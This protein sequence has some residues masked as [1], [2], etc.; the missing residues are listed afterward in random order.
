MKRG[1]LAMGSALALALALFAPG[2]GA[3]TIVVNDETDSGSFDHSGCGLRDAVEAANDN[4]AFGLCNGD[5]AGPD[6]IVLQSGHTYQLQHGVDDNNVNGDLDISGPTTITTDGPGLATIDAQSNT[7]PCCPAGADRAIHVLSTA[8]AVTLDHLRI[9]E[10]HVTAADF[11]GGGGIL[12]QAP[13]TL[14][15]SVVDFNVVTGTAHSLGGGIFASGSLATLNVV[16]STIADNNGLAVGN[17][18][19]QTTGGGIAAYNASPTVNITNSTVSGNTV[20]GSAGA[21]GGPGIVAGA[22]LGDSG[23]HPF[24]TLNHVTITDNHALQPGNGFNGGL[25]LRAGSMTGNLIAGNTDPFNST[26]DCDIGGVTSGG[27]NL[28]GDDGSVTC[29]LGLLNGPGDLVGS[30]ASPIPAN[31]GTLLDNG[32]PTRTHA[33]NPGSPAIAR[34]GNTCPDTD[35]RGFVRA[36]VAPCDAGAFEAG[37]L[38]PP[39]SSGSPP[40]AGPSAPV[41]PTAPKKKC[42]KHKKHKAAAAKKCKKKKKK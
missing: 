12:T 17:A 23:N 36:P 7:F 24:A 10:G 16:G 15:N 35:Q 19:P 13:L 33:L 30:H 4:A 11:S 39:S 21:N 34:G 31:L 6:R 3:A 42:K 32:G 25:E 18:N 37:A 28:I 14:V 20:Q 1:M 26:P 8:G 41:A 29:T 38:P 5:N 9:T 2:A 27:G 22:F 40:G